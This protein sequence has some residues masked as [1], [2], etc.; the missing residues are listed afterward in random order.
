MYLG[1]VENAP[2]N[3]NGKEWYMTDIQQEYG[4]L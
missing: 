1:V 4:L 3:G 2:E